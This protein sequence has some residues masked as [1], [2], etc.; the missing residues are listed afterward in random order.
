MKVFIDGKSGTTGLRIHSR[1]KARND[2]ELIS[3]PETERRNP[4]KRKEAIN[5]SDVTFLCLPDEAAK[6]SMSLVD[7]PNVTIIDASTAHRTDPNWA[8]GFPELSDKFRNAITYGKAL[9]DN[10]AINNNRKIAVPGCHAGGFIAL[11]YPLIE[12]KILNADSMLSCFSITGYSGGGKNMI[13]DYEDSSRSSLLDSPAQYAL[14]QTHKHLPE[15]TI[16]TGLNNSPI[17]SPIVSNFYSGMI[18]TIPIFANQLPKG[19]I[20]EDIANIYSVKYSGPIVKYVDNIN[21]NAF[22]YG[23]KLQGK[24]SMQISVAGNKD[25]MLLIAAYDNIGKGASGAALQCMNIA[26][27]I[28]ETKGLE[29]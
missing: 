14:G 23:N 7:N 17:F 9:K 6:E 21:K 19:I 2:V 3:L 22:I 8:Y 15:M 18:V 11:I 28:A 10:K 5:N 24:D 20:Y 16:I 13:A 25:R 27:G 29:L 12:A 4:I 1:L 26:M